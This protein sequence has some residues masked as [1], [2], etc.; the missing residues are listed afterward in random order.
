LL[1]LLLIIIQDGT[2]NFNAPKATTATGWT[3]VV[4]FDKTITTLNAWQGVVSGCLGGTVCTFTSQVEK[5]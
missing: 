1:L 4:T 5:C 3:M 2:F